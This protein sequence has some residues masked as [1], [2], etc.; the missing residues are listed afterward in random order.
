MGR[1][2]SAVRVTASASSSARAL[3]RRQLRTE[4]SFFRKTRSLVSS[5]GASVFSP[6]FPSSEG[7]HPRF[8]G[9][10]RH[11]QGK[12]CLESRMVAVPVSFS[13]MAQAALDL[14]ATAHVGMCETPTSPTCLRAKG[15]CADCPAALTS[16]L[17][18]FLYRSLQHPKP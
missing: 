13:I 8:D 14:T 4:G 3:A 7:G 15:L 9:A 10:H 18:P 6:R 12:P 17:A 1:S 16:K 5:T 2:W 11:V